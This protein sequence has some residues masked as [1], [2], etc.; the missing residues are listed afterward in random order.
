MVLYYK[1]LLPNAGHSK[2]ESCTTQ[3][4]NL[5]KSQSRWRRCSPIR[6]TPPYFSRRLVLGQRDESRLLIIRAQ[7]KP[8]LSLYHYAVKI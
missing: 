5:I 3:K 4:I 1:I 6:T 8:S 7:G 2:I